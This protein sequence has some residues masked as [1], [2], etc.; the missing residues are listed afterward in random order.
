MNA[1]SHP[2]GIEGIIIEEIDQETNDVITP[3]SG[4]FYSYIECNT[5][6]YVTPLTAHGREA[7]YENDD[8]IVAHNVEPQQIRGFDVDITSALLNHYEREFLQGGQVFER[9]SYDIDIGNMVQIPWT[10]ATQVWR[11]PDAAYAMYVIAEIPTNSTAGTTTVV[12][13][14]SRDHFSD[15]TNADYEQIVQSD[16]T[17]GLCRYVF[18]SATSSPIRSIPTPDTLRAT[19]M[20]IA[21]FRNNQSGAIFTWEDIEY[22]L[23]FRCL[24]APALL[25]SR[26]SSVVD[27]YDSIHLAYTLDSGVIDMLTSVNASSVTNTMQA[28]SPI[29][30]QY[31]DKF[32]ELNKDIYISTEENTSAGLSYGL[33]TNR[34][35]LSFTPNDEMLGT[36]AR[37]VFVVYY[38][39]P[40]STT[41]FMF[42]HS[43][44]LSLLT[45]SPKG[46]GAFIG[47]PYENELAYINHVENIKT[48]DRINDL[49]G[50]EVDYKSRYDSPASFM[51]N[52]RN[53][54]RMTI[55]T[56]GYTQN[57]NTFQY[58]LTFPYCWSEISGQV[59]NN[60]F[61]PDEWVVHARDDYINAKP[62]LHIISVDRQRIYPLQV[63]TDVGI[64]NLQIGN[65][66]IYEVHT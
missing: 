35:T 25:G 55:L 22:T 57:N 63:L 24:H 27:K 47:Q 48:V 54:F 60:R 50:L 59:L 42:N 15:V 9:G 19:Y 44:G 17:I 10:W 8:V 51:R 23:S 6:A 49:T 21:G 31:N 39:T 52:P 46:S 26:T 20:V 43:F 16:G 4:G 18:P 37:I 5:S 29:I 65:G 28:V 36:E 64:Q 56:E 30:E 33:Y 2:I 13:T 53:V 40:D 66:Q 34:Y 11:G 32:I 61:N 7:F 45:C 62:A 1:T 41:D 38:D 58:Q 3:E 14:S 12:K